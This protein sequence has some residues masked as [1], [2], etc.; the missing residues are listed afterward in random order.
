MVTGGAG[1][2][3]VT[4]GELHRERERER[5]RVSDLVVRSLASL[6]LWIYA[7]GIVV[8]N[9]LVKFVSQIV[10]RFV[11]QIVCLHFVS[12]LRTASQSYSIFLFSF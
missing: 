10:S 8:A 7:L 11:C 5:E 4:G 9:Y 3:H 12:I 6:L 2:C 1:H